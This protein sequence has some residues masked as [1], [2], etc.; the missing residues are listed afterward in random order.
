MRMLQ[1]N[2]N[3]RASMQQA[4]MHP[5][6]RDV[7]VPRKIEAPPSIPSFSGINSNQIRENAP[8]Q[9]SSSFESTGYDTNDTSST[10]PTTPGMLPRP[11]QTVDN[12]S[13]ELEA[14]AIQTNPGFSALERSTSGLSANDSVSYQPSLSDFPSVPGMPYPILKTASGVQDESPL[15]INPL[16]SAWSLSKI[17][18]A[19]KAVDDSMNGLVGHDTIRP[20]TR[21]KRKAR[22]TSQPPSSSPLSSPRSTFEDGDTRQG[23]DDLYLTADEGI[24]APSDAEMSIDRP[25]S[26]SSGG[27]RSATGDPMTPT[28][29]RSRR[30]F[31]MEGQTGPPVFTEPFIKPIKASRPAPA[32]PSA[33]LR[34]R[35]SAVATATTVRRPDAKRRKV[36]APGSE[37]ATVTPASTTQSSKARTTRRSLAATT[38]DS[39]NLTKVPRTTRGSVAAGGPQRF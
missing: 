37:D 11:L 39:L 21:G 14:L 29:L 32:P 28:R 20:A 13:Q 1:V 18:T 4:L 24:G 36:S 31:P 30:S 15:Q 23:E 3:Q 33:N 34:P 16:Q 27:R 22:P 38:N 26:P 19:P 35:K 8:I 6:I 9:A 2:P 12:C 7:V 10:T 17:G 5:W 25:G